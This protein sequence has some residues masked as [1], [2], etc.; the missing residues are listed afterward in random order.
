V[1]SVHSVF[2]KILNTENT[3][4]TEKFYD[5]SF[6]D[7]FNF[8]KKRERLHKTYDHVYVILRDDTFIEL[9]GTRVS[10]SK[11]CYKPVQ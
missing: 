8:S 9:G 2:K 6:V 3:E 1:F 4:Y 11:D 5:Q 7:I 10:V